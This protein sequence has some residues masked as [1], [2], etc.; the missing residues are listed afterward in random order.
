[1]GVREIGCHWTLSSWASRE[2]TAVGCPGVTDLYWEA[3]RVPPQV[4]HWCP[5]PEVGVTVPR[6]ACVHETTSLPRKC[7]RDGINLLAPVVFT[8]YSLLK[9][10]MC[11]Q[12]NELVS[13]G[14][15]LAMALRLT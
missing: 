5:G 11:E 4:G 9:T 14:T 6:C 15:I 13:P 7:E 2:H 8:C 3:V 1:M 10:P 12:F